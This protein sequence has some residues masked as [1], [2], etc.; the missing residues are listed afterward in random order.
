MCSVLTA[1][2]CEAMNTAEFESLHAGRPG[3]EKVDESV[4]REEVAGICSVATAAEMTKL[5]FLTARLRDANGR[6]EDVIK[7]KLH[8]M[9]QQLVG[10]AEHAVGAAEAGERLPGHFL[11]PLIFFLLRERHEHYRPFS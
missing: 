1:A 4:I 6:E 11:E 3:K 7:G 8:S 5:V 2:A 9:A 10:R